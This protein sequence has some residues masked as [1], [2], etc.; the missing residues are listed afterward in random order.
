MGG[1]CSNNPHAAYSLR[2]ASAR[3][4]GGD[5]S[6]LTVMGG[7]SVETCFPQG[8]TEPWVGVFCGSF[9]TQF[10]LI[11]RGWGGCYRGI[12]GFPFL[13]GRCDVAM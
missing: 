3:S 10:D 5:V 1:Q 12:G 4:H 11:G 9:G 2:R 7:M 13:G 8:C 6:P